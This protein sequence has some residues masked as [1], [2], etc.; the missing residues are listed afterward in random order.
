MLAISNIL[1]YY[2]I[3]FTLTMALN[4]GQKLTK[5]L[6]ESMCNDY[7]STFCNPLVTGTLELK[8]AKWV[9]AIDI[10][11]STD[12]KLQSN[13][14]KIVTTE[15]E[16][17]KELISKID[18]KCGTIDIIVWN[19][20]AQTC[21]L[22]NLDKLT[23][24]N[25]TEP[26]CMFRSN[27]CSD[28]ISKADALMV[29]TD[30]DIEQPSVKSFG[31]AITERAGHL[32]A[33]VG[34]LVSKR[35]KDQSTTNDK[36]PSEIDVSVL[37]PAMI[38]DGCILYHDGIETFVMWSSGSFSRMWDPRD[39]DDTTTW[40]ELTLVGIE[41][42]DITN[43]TCTTCDP[44][45]VSLLTTK[46][47]IPIGDGL[48]IH[49]SNLLKTTPSFNELLNLPFSRICQ[50]F[51]VTDRYQELYDWF[52]EQ[53]NRLIKEIMILDGVATDDDLDILAEKIMELPYSLRCNSNHKH[54]LV[55][56]FTHARNKHIAYR[57]LDVD[58]D[59]E[60]ELAT[61]TAN[62]LGKF[63]CEMTHIMD[64][65]MELLNPTQTKK[66]QYSTQSVSQ[67]KYTT[68]VHCNGK[69]PAKQSQSQKKSMKLSFNNPYCWERKMYQTYPEDNTNNYPCIECSVCFEYTI[70]YLLVRSC[71]DVNKL[72]TQNPF[73]RFN[74]SMVCAKCAEFCCHRGK[75]PMNKPCIAAIPFFE[76][77]CMSKKDRKNHIDMFSK[78]LDSCSQIKYT[79]V[80][81]FYVSYDDA[82]KCIYQKPKLPDTTE[83]N[84]KAMITFAQFVMNYIPD[85]TSH[86]VKQYIKSITETHNV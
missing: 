76:Y 73:E 20:N 86:I 64:E 38:G 19:D 14:K 43:V 74:P 81:M 60:R 28:I 72:D 51:R 59:I 33:V 48:F 63:L 44:Y 12:H 42:S 1:G 54:P 58:I 34:V 70:P 78:L 68:T 52:K 66:S 46:G 37:V 15:I 6:L 85:T 13:E 45:Q 69:T 40:N 8:N 56:A 50:Y 2:I 67:T 23:G 7:A 32:K 17:A 53:K 24:T 49:P 21:T 10:S 83:Q 47:Y 71:F 29:I 30:G 57:H 77:K 4:L 84:V 26:Y 80:G 75:N 79:K 31:V 27:Q 55:E 62:K 35:Y 22:S 82:G 9:V 65:D 41:C 36:P 3:P 11:G 18:P 16:Y 5:Q 25:G 61:G 39:I